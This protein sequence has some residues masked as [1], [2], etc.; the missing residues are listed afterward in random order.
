MGALE[1]EMIEQPDKKH[2]RYAAEVGRV[3]HTFNVGD[4]YELQGDT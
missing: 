3:L 4:F 2:L 1:A